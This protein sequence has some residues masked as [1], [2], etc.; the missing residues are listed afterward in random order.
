MRFSS[1]SLRLREAMMGERVD[2][3]EYELKMV[4]YLAKATQVVKE[5][6][7]KRVTDAMGKDATL[8]IFGDRGE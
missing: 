2:M 1:H 6:T 4:C 5:M 3:T 7:E 8:L